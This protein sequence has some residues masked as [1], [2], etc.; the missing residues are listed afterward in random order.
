MHLPSDAFANLESTRITTDKPGMALYQGRLAAMFSR[1]LL[2]VGHWQHDDYVLTCS[3]RY[4]RH[5]TLHA[6]QAH[7]ET[8]KRELTDGQ[9]GSNLKRDV[10]DILRGRVG[11]VSTSV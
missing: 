2:V 1:G 10:V 7:L 11:D 3:R 8:G 6:R 5:R 9:D 4:T